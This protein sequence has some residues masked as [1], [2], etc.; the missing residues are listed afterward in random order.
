MIYDG[1]T[2]VSPS[3]KRVAEISLRDT[4][5]RLGDLGSARR[6]CFV[7]NTRDNSPAVIF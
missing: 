6:R 2:N 1:L 4:R 3:N 7:F 5:L